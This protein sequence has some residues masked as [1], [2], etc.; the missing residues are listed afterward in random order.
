MDKKNAIKDWFRSLMFVTGLHF[1]VGYMK[2][3]WLFFL[4]SLF[5]AQN[6]LYSQ[7]L[8]SDS[9]KALIP[10]RTGGRLAD[11]YLDIGLAIMQETGS[12]DTLVY[13]CQVSLIESKKAKDLQEQVYAYKLMSAAQS[14]A[15]NYEASNKNLASALNLAITIQDTASVADINNKLGYNCQMENKTEEALNY[16]LQAAS[17]FELMQNW[18]E[19]AIAYLNVSTVFSSLRRP[20]EMKRYIDKMLG[21]LPKLKNNYNQVTVLSA[22]ANSY[23]EFSE[24]T[25]EFGD[26]AI[27][28]AEAGLKLAYTHQIWNKYAELL[29]AEGNVYL[30]RK[31]YETGIKF[32]KESLLYREHLRGVVVY[33]AMMGLQIAYQELGQLQLS[34]CYLDSMKMETNAQDYATYRMEIMEASYELYKRMGDTRRALV[35]LEEFKQLQDSL[36]SVERAAK[37]SELE[38]QYNRVKNEKTIQELSQQQEIYGQKNEIQD[39]RITQLI[40]GIALLLLVVFL[41]GFIFWTSNK[42][43]ER[44]LLEAEQRLNRARMNPHFVFNVLAAIQT[45]TLDEQRK[46]EVGAYIA[47]FSKIMRQSLES[48]FNELTS[49]EEELGFL[50]SYLDLQTL[51]TNRKFSYELSVDPHLDVFDVRLPGMILQPF[52]ENAIEHGFRGMDGGGRLL[53][54][55]QKSGDELVIEINDN[56]RSVSADKTNKLYPSRATQIITD[57]LYLLKAKTK[58]EAHFTL[59]QTA[60][61]GMQVVIF[62]PLL[63]AP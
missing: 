34:E 42:N 45:L 18:D 43:K 51:L 30:L 24:T 53:I 59:S 38:Q 10:E 7:P 37:I 5:L 55:I 12:T 8:V 56:G 41:G 32:Y 23:A 20:E 44:K 13:Y 52:I 50:A 17:S 11:L 9:L 57:R 19:L 1:E 33:N 54:S 4:L 31:S 49:L 58:K 28:Y 25:P 39:L 14:V 15:A 2:S 63:Y 16:Y 48:T 22:A 21:L 60:E 29:I 3:Y 40:F 61:G 6:E 46:K 35:A 36:V 26:S 47:R 62:L 27:L